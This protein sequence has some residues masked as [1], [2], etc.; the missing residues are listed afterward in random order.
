[1]TNQSILVQR[2][3]YV[4]D[5]SSHHFFCYEDEEELTAAEASNPIGN[6]DMQTQEPSIGNGSK[7]PKW[8]ASKGKT[9]SKKVH[10][11]YLQRLAMVEFIEIPENFN[12]I[13]GKK[14]IHGKPIGGIIITK[15]QAYARMA[16]KVNRKQK[17]S[18]WDAK[19]A[20]GRFRTYK[21]L[22]RSALNE[23]RQT[24]WGITAEDQMAGITSTSSKL[25]AKCPLFSRLDALYGHRENITPTIV[26][27]QGMP[28]VNKKRKLFQEDAAESSSVEST[29]GISEEMSETDLE[30]AVISESLAMNS[31]SS[32]TEGFTPQDVSSV[33][34]RIGSGSSTSHASL[35]N[36]TRPMQSAK[37]PRKKAK[38]SQ[39][40]D[41]LINLQ[42]EMFE[43][44]MI[45]EEKRQERD[46]EEKWREREA[47][48]QERERELEEKNHSLRRTMIADLCKL[49][50]SPQEIQEYL[51]LL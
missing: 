29:D 7:A 35:A 17:G 25:E 23:S 10:T 46:H 31:G 12:A 16:A 24:G 27:H 51:E 33:S 6:V 32:S 4:A 13:E 38:S 9:P 11:T 50:K 42:R 26:H 37:N 41:S 22:Y 45:A 43:A 28:G 47:K 1:M 36:Q 2:E 44:R 20:S 14:Q 30:T 39:Q 5:L 8:K 19:A 34:Q 21:T 3:G 49:G 40:L 48:V 18:D 15:K